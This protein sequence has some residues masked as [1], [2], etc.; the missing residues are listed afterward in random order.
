MTVTQI[1]SILR[2]R[3]KFCVL[4]LLAVPL[5]ILAGSL[6]LTKRYQ[7]TA[8]VLVDVKPDPISGAVFG[9]AANTSIMA[10]QVD[11]ITSDRV[12][13]RVI[14]NLKLEQQP[15]LQ[16]QWQEATKGTGSFEDWVGGRLL[17]QLD[18]RPSRDSNVINI[19]YL[20]P[21]PQFA[22][23]MANAFVQAYLD[24]SIELK[25]DPARQYSAFFEDRAKDARQALASAQ[26][27][28]SSFQKKEGIVGSDDR[29]DVETQ[30]LNEINSQLVMAQSLAAD[31][32]SRQVQ[33]AGGKGDRLAEAMSNPV[34]S[35]LRVDL[36]RAEAS[37]QE[38]KSRM[39]DNNPQVVQARANI[40][41]LR[42]RLD[43][44]VR[45]V[46]GSVEVASN[47]S[48][49]RVA[50]IRAQLEAQ[51]T[52]ILKLQETRDAMAV[53]QRDVDAAQKAY[54][55]I[56][57][58]RNQ[59]SLEGQSQQSNVNVLSVA[60]IPSAPA[61]PRIALNVVVGVLLGML[62]AIGGALLREKFDLRV[63]TTDDLITSLGLPVL[64]VMPH[65]AIRRGSQLAAIQRVISGRLPAPDNKK[66]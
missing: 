49:G 26:E 48:S 11:I 1:L 20:A 28:L 2:A 44:E 31:S 46:S 14:R 10:T 32:T 4:V 61:S 3:W 50:A 15:A 57:G 51:R 39:G 65:P 27:K 34:V 18:V 29:L 58:Q 19:G 53:L 23:T 40:A 52:K 12:V 30:R 35:S 54:D 62:L 22:A 63:R 16:A 60:T 47:I 64:G 59:S 37:L 21:D 25:A 7:A 24:T 9:G 8:S 36:N 17:A 41:E 13:R 66:S 55:A 6:M 43:Q 38:L 33:A 5:L 42:A 45:R 56:V